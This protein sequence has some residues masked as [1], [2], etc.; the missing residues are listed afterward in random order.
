M[1]CTNTLTND[2]HQHIGTD[3]LYF[4]GTVFSCIIE[5]NRSESL[6]QPET[7]SGKIIILPYPMF[8]QHIAVP[9]D[10]HFGI[11]L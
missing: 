8:N 6:S 9:R 5:I 11:C 10:K 4:F 2:K 7:K 3:T 1:I